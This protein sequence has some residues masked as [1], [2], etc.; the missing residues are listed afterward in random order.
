MQKNRTIKSAKAPNHSLIKSAKAQNHP[1]KK[2]TNHPIKKETNNPIK[3]ETNNPIKKEINHPIKKETNNPIKKEINHPIKKEANNPIKKETN[4]PIKKETNHPIKKEINH[5]IKKETNNPIKK[6]INHPI[7]KETNLKNFSKSINLV[8]NCASD[9]FCVFKSII[10]IFHLIYQKNKNYIISYD[11]TNLQVITQIQSN[12]FYKEI[13]YFFDKNNKRDLILLLGF[14]NLKIYDNYNW[15][16]V[17]YI[18]ESIIIGINNNIEGMKGKDTK[19]GLNSC[20]LN[21]NKNN[22]IITSTFDSEFYKVYDF[23]GKKIKDIKSYFN[24]TVI[25]SYKNYILSGNI[26]FC[27]S[28]NFDTKKVKTYEHEKVALFEYNSIMVYNS[29]QGLLLIGKRKENYNVHSILIWNFKLALLINKIDYKVSSFDS[30][31]CL[32]NDNYYIVGTGFC[33]KIFD[34]SKKKFIKEIKRNEIV[35]NFKKIVHPKYGECLMLIEGQ[36]AIIIYD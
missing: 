27:I 15:N 26:M 5:P 23:N 9:S 17:V 24:N 21:N 6:E 7:K 4:N 14:D 35:Y 22:Y 3:K 34:N 18:K 28:Y 10:N 12:E 36:N 32:W 11:L 29:K 33:F 25:E 30:G 31:L 20:I 16:C 2:E 8:N 13:K 19:C 1:I